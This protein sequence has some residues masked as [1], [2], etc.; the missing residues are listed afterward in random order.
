MASFIDALKVSSDSS[1]SDEVEFYDAARFKTVVWFPK[2]FEAELKRCSKPQIRRKY[3]S[4]CLIGEAH[5]EKNKSLEIICGQNFD[6][7]STQT[8]GILANLFGDSNK[9]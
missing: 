4:I 8:K 6:V 5:F 3:K 9:D 1:F 2:E 7:Y